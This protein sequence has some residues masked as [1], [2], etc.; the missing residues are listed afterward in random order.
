LQEWR[1]YITGIREETGEGNY[2]PEIVEPYENNFGEKLSEFACEW[3]G[4]GHDKAVM[5]IRLNYSVN[6]VRV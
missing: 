5:H 4:I 1:C 6:K 3:T 2:T